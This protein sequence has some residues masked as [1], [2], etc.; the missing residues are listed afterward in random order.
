MNRHETTKTGPSARA[1]RIRAAFTSGVW[2]LGGALVA[3]LCCAPPAVTF[4]LGLGGSTFL[5]GLAQ[6]KPYFALAGLAMMAPVGWRLL[7]PVGHC[8][9]RERRE[10]LARLALVLAVFGGG[11]LAIN[12]LL[13]P[14]LYTF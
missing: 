4:V 7:R 14:W 2:G 8:E 3:S 9:V 6:Y 10:R 12:Y 11:Y 13:L 5:V 1:T